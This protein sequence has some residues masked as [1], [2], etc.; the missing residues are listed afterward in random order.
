MLD[1]QPHNCACNAKSLDPPIREL[2][3][4][5]REP[6]E[7]MR[8]AYTDVPQPMTRL[9]MTMMIV[10]KPSQ[11]QSQCLNATPPHPIHKLTTEC[12]DLQCT[13][14]AHPALLQPDDVPLSDNSSSDP[15]L[16]FY[17]RLCPPHDD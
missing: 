5:R 1:E 15:M 11:P 7:V 2:L 17:N 13:M 8:N 16:S 6:Q 3:R 14:H 9:L 12:N 10:M 4:M